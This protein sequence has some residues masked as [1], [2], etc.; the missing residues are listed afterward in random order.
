MALCLSLKPGRD[1]LNL[2][3]ELNAII[4]PLVQHWSPS[5]C[6]ISGWIILNTSQI[7]TL[8]SQVNSYHCSM[9]LVFTIPTAMTRDSSGNLHV[10]GLPGIRSIRYDRRQDFVPGYMRCPLWIQ[11]FPSVTRQIQALPEVAPDICQVK[12][13]FDAFPFPAIWNVLYHI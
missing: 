7:L 12:K 2:N 11:M 1:R 5:V 10:S 3:R 6:R 8:L 13:S 9:I 4:F